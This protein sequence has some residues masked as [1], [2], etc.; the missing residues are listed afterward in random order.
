MNRLPWLLVV[1]ACVAPPAWAHFAIER[2]TAWQMTR[3]GMVCGTSS[4][5]IQ[6]LAC[7]AAGTLS[8]T[9]ILIRGADAGWWKSKPR[10]RGPELALLGLPLLAASVSPAWLM[11][12]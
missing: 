4:W 8:I 10:A 7:I 12:W 9:A 1:V 11:T 3:F 2:D 6:F 5:I